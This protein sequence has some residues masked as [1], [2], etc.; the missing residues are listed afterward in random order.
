MLGEGAEQ[1]GGQDAE[2]GGEADESERRSVLASLFDGDDEGAVLLA[3]ISECC[4]V[5]PRSVRISRTV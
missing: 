1:P 2:G 5:M 3:E 4:W